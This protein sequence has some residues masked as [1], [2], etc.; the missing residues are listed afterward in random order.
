MFRTLRRSDH[1]AAPRRFRSLAIEALE[2]RDLLSGSPPQVITVEVGS[3]A[4]SS[5]FVQFLQ[6]TAQGTNGYSIP[7]GSSAQSASLTWKNIDRVMITFNKD[8]NIDINDLT[9]SG[10][11]MVAYQFSGFHYDPHTCVASWTLTAPINKDRLRLE[12]NADGLDPVTDL[13][14]NRLDGEWTN[15]VS[16]ISGNGSEGG[17]FGFHINVLPDDVTNTGTVSSYDYVYIRQLDGKSTT[18]TG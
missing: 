15:N 9:L 13:D 2:R 18:S 17:N 10:V 16:T 8:V 14:G 4:W 6:N 1:Y 7:K 5:A 3:T 11:N 12:L